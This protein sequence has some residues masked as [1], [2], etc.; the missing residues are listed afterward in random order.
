MS[1]NMLPLSYRYAWACVCGTTTF[2]VRIA[3]GKDWYTV[4]VHDTPKHQRCGE[5]D[6]KRFSP[7]TVDGRKVRD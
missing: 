3:P 1:R 7:K 4:G 6:K 5:S 2:A